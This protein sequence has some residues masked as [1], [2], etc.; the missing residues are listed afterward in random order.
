[1][2]QGCRNPDAVNYNPSATT[3]DY[4]CVYLFKHGSTCFKFIDVPPANLVDNSFTLSYSLLGQS[5]VF[6]H[7]YQPDLYVHTR[8][9]LYSLK[10]NVLFRH[11]E[12]APGTYYDNPKSFFI[13]VVFKAGG[14]EK[15]DILLETI[16][17]ITEFIPASGRD[18]IF[19]TLTHISAWN[20]RQHTGRIALAD[21]LPEPLPYSNRRTKGE[22]SFNDIRD[23]LKDDSNQFVDSLFRNYALLNSEVEPN[24]VWYEQ[25]ALEDRWI[26]V[27]F[28][29]DNT[30]NATVILHNT[31][32]TA[33][34]SNR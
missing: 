5:W 25:G 11:H 26:R 8:N 1:M 15:T 9:N 27:R 21:V 12:G 2:V 6:F 14:N 29:Y 23:I 3:E 18:A 33:Q 32:I 30:Q 10:N 16:N 13:D 24:P 31:E 20:S 17:W 34:L 4:S 28:E 22:W 19:S 7:D